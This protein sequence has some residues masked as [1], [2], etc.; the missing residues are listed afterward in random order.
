MRGRY[1]VTYRN[2]PTPRKLRIYGIVSLGLRATWEASKILIRHGKISG[3]RELGEGMAVKMELK[4]SMREMG[5]S[6]G[7]SKRR[8]G[9]KSKLVVGKRPNMEFPWFESIHVA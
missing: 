4:Q 5:G 8:D 2:F 6:A 3:Y 9:P 7:P 1:S